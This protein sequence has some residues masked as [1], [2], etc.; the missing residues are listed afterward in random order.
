MIHSKEDIHQEAVKALKPPRPDSED[1][2]ME[3][4]RKRD[5]PKVMPDFSQ[6]VKYI[7]DKVSIFCVDG[8]LEGSKS[9]ETSQSEQQGLVR[10]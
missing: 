5:G 7:K 10:S 9:T 2:K 6:M 1:G 8:A 4:E 3:W